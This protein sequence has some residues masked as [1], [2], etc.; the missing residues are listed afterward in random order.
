MRVR[1]CYIS[2]ETYAVALVSQ[3]LA[4]TIVRPIL[5][6]SN[7]VNNNFLCYIYIYT[8]SLILFNRYL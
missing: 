6:D 3:S 8:L 7:L 4:N 5:T 1:I 2:L